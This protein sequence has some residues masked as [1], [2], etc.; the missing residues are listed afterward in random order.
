MLTSDVLR[1]HFQR[2]LAYL[3]Y[4]A[5]G[6][7]AHQEGWNAMLARVALSGA[8]RELIASF[9]RELNVL[10]SSGTWCGDCVAQGPML[11][12]IREANP[13]R[14]HLRFVDR[15]AHA[16]LA[17]AIRICGGLRVPTVIFLN[18]DFEFLSLLGDRTLTRYRAI[19]VKQLGAACPLPGAPV[20]QDEVDATLQ[21]WVDEFERA[22]LMVR[23]SPR[24]RA[25]H[26]N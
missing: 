24:L 11:E 6:K 20:P 1:D 25:K 19:A 9:T 10:V 12:R 18:E 22:Q 14:I 16:D 15:D 21:D 23:L 26:G 7:P 17:S 13:G 4:V 3:P 8:Q 5:T 2:G